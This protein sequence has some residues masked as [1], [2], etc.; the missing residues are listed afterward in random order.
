MAAL[1]LIS[2]DHLNVCAVKVIVDQSVN[3]VSKPVHHHL[4]STG[5]DVSKKA[6]DHI[7]VNVCTTILANIVSSNVISVT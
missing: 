3:N 6:I 7:D 4:V 5:V 2:S 1:V